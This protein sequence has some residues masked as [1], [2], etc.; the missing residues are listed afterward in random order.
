VVP[1]GRR[2]GDALA[3][4]NLGLLCLDGE[5]VPQNYMQ[6]HMWISLAAAK[7]LDNGRDRFAIA[8]LLRA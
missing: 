7:A 4:N 5:G 2:P 1:Q 6:A 3:Q 8:S